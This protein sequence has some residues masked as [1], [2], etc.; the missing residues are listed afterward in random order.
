MAARSLLDFFKPVLKGR[1]GN[2]SV[3]FPADVMWVKAALHG[4]GRYNPQGVIRPFITAGMEAALRSYQKDCGLLP[5]GRL[6]PGSQT[7]TTM[8]LELGRILEGRHS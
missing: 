4:L 3:N 7:E 6:H 8:R 5:D 2:G 1:V